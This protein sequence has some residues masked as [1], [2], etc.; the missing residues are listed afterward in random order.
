MLGAHSNCRLENLMNFM[1]RCLRFLEEG[2]FAEDDCSLSCALFYGGFLFIAE[3]TIFATEV[4][5]RDRIGDTSSAA[6]RRS[7]SRSDIQ[8]VTHDVSVIQAAPGHFKRQAGHVLWSRLELMR[9]FKTPPD[10]Q[11]MDGTCRTL[12]DGTLWEEEKK[13][14]EPTQPEQTSTWGESRVREA[15]ENENHRSSCCF[16]PELTRII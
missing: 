16:A 7:K 11:L 12:K 6:S 8:V 2:I 4:V 13:K 15:E 3:L 9:P 5:W 1:G 14:R 10:L